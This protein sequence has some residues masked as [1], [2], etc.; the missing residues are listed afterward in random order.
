MTTQEID[1]T[2]QRIDARKA[3]KAALLDLGKVDYE[4]VRGDLIGKLG[5]DQFRELQKEIFREIGTIQF[6]KGKETSQG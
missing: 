3:L 2:Y 4:R 6:E 1:S 5:Y